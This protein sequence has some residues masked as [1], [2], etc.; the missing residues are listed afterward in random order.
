[1]EF[2]VEQVAGE[3]EPT[4]ELLFALWADEEILDLSEGQFNARDAGWGATGTSGVYRPKS[5]TKAYFRFPKSALSLGIQGFKKKTKRNTLIEERTRLA[6]AVER[7]RDRFAARHDAELT[8][9]LRRNEFWRLVREEVVLTSNGQPSGALVGGGF[10]GAQADQL[11]VV[12]ADVDH[13]K[14][15]N[16]SYGHRYG[17][18]VLWAVAQR[19]RKLA[20]GWS[21][22]GQLSTRLG[23]VGGE[24]FS[25]S[26]SGD[27]TRQ[28]IEEL[29]HEI[30]NVGV[31][32][33]L[34]TDDEV[35]EFGW[36]DPQVGIPPETER[37]V[38]MSA[39]V[40]FEELDH[41]PTKRADQVSQM[42]ERADRALR[43]SKARGRRCFT[44]FDQIKFSFGRVLE[45]HR[46]TGVVTID[47][48]LTVGVRE[49]DVFFVHHP[50]FDGTHPF[51]VED[52]RTRRTLGVRPKFRSAAIEVFDVS[53]AISSCRIRS[54]P[55]TRELAVVPN[56]V[57]EFARLGDLKLFSGTARA[58]PGLAT[59]ISK[60][61]DAG[62]WTHGVLCIP[63]V[64]DLA[65]SHGNALTSEAID[66][67]EKESR[68][69]APAGALFP[70]ERVPGVTSF[71]LGGSEDLTKWWG[72]FKDAM[73]G[74][75]PPGAKV[76]LGVVSSTDVVPLTVKELS[77][78]DVH[79]V[80]RMAAQAGA[81]VPQ[82]MFG[83]NEHVISFAAYVRRLSGQWDEGE[84]ELLKWRALGV[85]SGHLYNQLA[86][87]RWRKGDVA[88]AQEYLVEAVEALPDDPTI[89]S[90]LASASAQLRDFAKAI[91]L[92]TNVAVVKPQL[93]RRLPTYQF[94]LRAVL[95]ALD[96]GVDVEECRRLIELVGE[97]DGLADMPR[98]TRVMRRQVDTTLLSRG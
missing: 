64:E 43:T 93:L 89:V 31:E 58:F 86:L 40:S 32:Q 1:M 18:L 9:L 14:Q 98:A 60:I 87:F 62:D 91:T 88:K 17:D 46:E 3:L 49:G 74:A 97:P 51:C 16:D 84:D 53:S 63:N 20:D 26:L 94:L 81:Q 70:P 25:F 47:V 79:W 61:R 15:L 19:L 65:E 35:R 29:C 11:A 2:V 50:D 27:V 30:C 34:P 36:P 13:F 76:T 5:S 85:H 39:G 96:E 22:P 66:Q 44:F 78:E 8:G 80:A 23:R 59:E 68:A 77:D 24:E 55:D 95:G 10:G 90:N 83:L 75:L 7:A 92:F 54:S 28:K 82:G 56:A 12:T 41:D 57:L 6:H 21:D 4:L 52:G 67:L 45:H 33:C 37:R 72:S 71:W 73:A 69:R 48:G 42:A 38:A